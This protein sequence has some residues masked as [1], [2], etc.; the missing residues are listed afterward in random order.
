[1]STGTCSQIGT[2]THTVAGA[3]TKEALDYLETHRD[4]LKQELL[5]LAAIPSV[6]A[7]PEYSESCLKAAKWLENRMNV[8]GLEVSI[9]NMYFTKIHKTIK[10]QGPLTCYLVSWLDT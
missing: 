5:D 3:E 10:L 6:S 7:I 2:N 1:M 8:A 4:R 9:I